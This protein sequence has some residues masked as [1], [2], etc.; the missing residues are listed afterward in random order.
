MLVR[1]YPIAITS[2]IIPI[3]LMNC[4]DILFCH[5]KHSADP[6]DRRA[7]AI[8]LST[9]DLMP[10][11]SLSVLLLTRF[12]AIA[13]DIAVLILTW[14]KTFHHWRGLRQLKLGTSIS[15]LL[16]RDG[17][18]CYPLVNLIELTEPPCCFVGTLYFL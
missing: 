12:C 10:P 14:V 7:F 15:T 5:L 4:M 16:L 9:C 8:M 6:L 18:V 2:S 1:Q 11:W 13:A 3:A 17:K